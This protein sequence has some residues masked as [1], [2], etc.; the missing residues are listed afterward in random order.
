MVQNVNATLNVTLESY[1]FRI[2]YSM[3]PCCISMGN[4]NVQRP[5]VKFANNFT[6]NLPNDTK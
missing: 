6:C 1:Q 2:T 5:G 3:S 4:T